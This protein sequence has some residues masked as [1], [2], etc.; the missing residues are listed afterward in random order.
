MAA[1]VE[2]SVSTGLRST[3]TGSRLD[4]L[5]S[6]MLAAQQNDADELRN[7]IKKGHSVRDRDK[8]G[9]TALHYCA[10]NSDLTCVERVCLSF[11]H[12]IAFEPPRSFDCRVRFV[13]AE[14][15]LME[16]PETMNAQDEEGF[17]ALHLAVICGNANV[18]KFLIRKGADIGVLDNEGHS[19]V[20]W[21]TVCGEVEVLDILLEAG[22]GA[23][24]R[25][26]HGATPLHYAA[27]LCAPTGNLLNG[28]PDRRIGLRTLKKLLQWGVPVTTADNDGRQSL[29]WAASAGSADAM[30]ALVNAGAR[31]DA[32][33]KDG[34]TALHCAASRGHVD[35]IETLVS[36]CGAEVDVLDANGCTALFYAVT[37]GHADCTQLLL[38]YGAEPNRQDRKGRT[39]AHCGAAKG[40]LETL[41]LLHGAGANIWARN[42]RGDVPLHEA[43]QSGRKDLVTWLLSSRPEAVNL[44]N[45]DGRCPLHIAAVNNNIE[46][47]KVL[48]DLGASTNP[49]MRGSRGQ[50]LTPLDAA[51]MRGNRNCAKYLQLHGASPASRLAAHHLQG[52][53]DYPHARSFTPSPDG[54]F[55]V[56]DGRRSSSLSHNKDTQ[57][58]VETVEESQQTDGNPR[59]KKGKEGESGF[60]MVAR[61]EP[62]AVGVEHVPAGGKDSGFSEVLMPEEEE[63]EEGKKAR[64]EAEAKKEEKGGKKEERGGKKEGK[65]K[66][67]M[68]HNGNLSSSLDSMSGTVMK[69]RVRRFELERKI[70]SELLE[71][72]RLQ[73]RSGKANE[74]LVVKRMVDRYKQ[75]GLLGLK[76]YDGPYTFRSFERFL[77]ALYPEPSRDP[78]PRALLASS[79]PLTALTRRVAARMVSAFDQLKFVQNPQFLKSMPPKSKIPQRVK[80]EGDG[81]GNR[82]DVRDLD[83]RVAVTTNPTMATNCTHRTHSCHHTAHAYTGIPCAAYITKPNHHHYLKGTQNFLPRIPNGG[84]KDTKAK[85]G[86]G[87]EG[88]GKEG[89]RKEGQGKEGQGQAPLGS[90]SNYDPTEP[91]TVELNHGGQRQLIEFPA[92]TLDKRKRYHVTFTIKP[93][94]P[95]AGLL[96]PAVNSVPRQVNS[97]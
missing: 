3:S 2:P 8:S 17:S 9:K 16:A 78:F 7:L 45:N 33:D 59:T 88:Q 64:R 85:E 53:S 60:N 50:L 73:I 44:G 66:E 39:P 24:T 23:D 93:S 55:N 76:G 40:Q 29:L 90:V 77:Y 75:E 4:G 80:G 13:E 57:A 79:L 70:F 46:M 20:H 48:L 5:T 43:I 42:I 52:L 86:L 26:L 28:G 54:T 82:S 38:Q 31:V 56:G 62:E 25:D 34:L 37:L 81:E 95:D 58:M 18:V 97:L 11:L 12:S 63:E 32:E 10:E 65:T 67:K 96:K 68:K 94:T 72:K 1:V 47:C 49:I 89:Q 30:L 19:L 87:K 51:L 36:L 15:I 14:G 41:R 71:L 21:A 22:S 74:S 84:K 61:G 91:L 83:E 92:H 6:L 69:N 27:Q 35:C